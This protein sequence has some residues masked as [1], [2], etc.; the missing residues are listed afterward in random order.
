VGTDGN[1]KILFNI[2]IREKTPFFM[3]PYI[4]EKGE[5]TTFYI[6][7]F[8]NIHKKGESTMFYYR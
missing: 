5:S 2:G 3:F 8:S 6:Y 4:H 1:N 7:I